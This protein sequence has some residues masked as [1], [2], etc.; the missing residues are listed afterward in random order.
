MTAWLRV[1]FA[2]AAFACSLPVAAQVIV[3]VAPGPEV[4]AAATMPDDSAVADADLLLQA[5]IGPYAEAHPDAV[6]A[7]DQRI[8]AAGLASALLQRLAQ[9]APAQWREGLL[10]AQVPERERLQAAL[11][12]VGMAVS[13]GPNWQRPIARA[14]SARFVGATIDGCA[15]PPSL[16]EFVART[17]FWAQSTASAALPPTLPTRP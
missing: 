14:Y 9:G 12:L 1:A 6:E 13:H 5:C 7:L 2:A 3:P 17:D 15:V 11:G 16:V 8:A 10:D 4:D